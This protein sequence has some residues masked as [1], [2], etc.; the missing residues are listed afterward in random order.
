MPRG[1]QQLIVLQKEFCVDKLQTNFETSFLVFILIIL[2]TLP[3]VTRPPH[4]ITLP[5]H[6]GEHGD[7]LG[8]GGAHHAAPPLHLL[9]CG[10]QDTGL[11]WT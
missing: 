1:D 6:Q 4:V 10:D 11:A 2:Q 7:G 3:E 9:V 8:L 5:G